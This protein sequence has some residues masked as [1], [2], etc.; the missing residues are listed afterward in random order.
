MAGGFPWWGALGPGSGNDGADMVGTNQ[1]SIS[2]R[3]AGRAPAIISAEA[4]CKG[5]KTISDISSL[6]SVE[7]CCKHKEVFHLLF[8]FLS[9]S[10]TEFTKCVSQKTTLTCQ[11]QSQ[12][13]TTPSSNTSICKNRYARSLW[14]HGSGSQGCVA[15]ARVSVASARACL[16]NRVVATARASSQKRRRS[17]APRTPHTPPLGSRYLLDTLTPI[18][19]KGA[20]ESVAVDTRGTWL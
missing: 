20:R 6:T 16:H 12:D 1:L 9:C 18:P 10:R 3:G 7:T 2:A 17:R 11:N 8:T 15:S 14:Y 13:P 5:S 19:T 4:T